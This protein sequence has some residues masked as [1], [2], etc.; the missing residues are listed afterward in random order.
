LSCFKPVL[1]PVFPYP[2]AVP[3]GGPAPGDTGQS[4]P[5]WTAVG[6]IQATWLPRG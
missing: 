4:T 5:R 1:N 2:T 6:S 3:F